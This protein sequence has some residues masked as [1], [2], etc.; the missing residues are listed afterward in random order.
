MLVLRA[1]LVRSV[2]TK[3][4]PGRMCVKS[5]PIFGSKSKIENMEK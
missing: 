2:G 3:G 5:T 4:I 1:F